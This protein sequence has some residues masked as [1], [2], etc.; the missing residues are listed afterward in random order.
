MKSAPSGKLIYFTLN[1]EIRCLKL[2]SSRISLIL[3]VFII[4]RSVMISN[5]NGYIYD[6]PLS[7]VISIFVCQYHYW[8]TWFSYDL[9]AFLKGYKIVYRY[10]GTHLV[11]YRLPY[12]DMSLLRMFMGTVHWSRVSMVTILLANH[13]SF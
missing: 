6:I 4:S 12:L 10:Q 11:P 8:P 9:I 7:I 3:L 5:G 13:F 2:F 1:F